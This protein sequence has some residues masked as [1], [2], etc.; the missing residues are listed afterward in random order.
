MNR[1]MS[2]KSDKHKIQELKEMIQEKDPN[3]PA[4]KVLAI[5]CE[6]HGV[7]LDTCRIYYKWLVEKGEIKEK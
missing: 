7:S 1:Q 6:R 2:D 4:E 3:E 5:F